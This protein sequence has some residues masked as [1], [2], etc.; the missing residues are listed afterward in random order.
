[1]AGGGSHQRDMAAFRYGGQINEDLQYRVYGN[2]FEVGPNYDPTGQ[3][4]DAWRQGHFGFRADWEPGRDKSNVITVQGDHYLG[5]TDNSVI[6]TD[7]T[8]SDYL[9]G[10]NLLVRWRHVYDEHSDW[11]LQAYYD[12]YTRI[13]AL[14]SE[15]DKT[16]DV[17]FQY[18]FALGDRHSITCGASFRNVES[19]FPG[20]DQFVN[21][22]PYPNLTTN[23]TS[24]FIQDEI[25]LVEDRL[26][27]TLGTKL[28]QNPYTGFEYQPTARVLWPP[29][30]RHSAWCAVSRAVRTPERL[31]EQASLTLA[32]AGEIYDLPLYPRLYGNQNAEFGSND[33][34]SEALVAYELGYREQTTEQLSWDIATFYNVYDHLIVPPA[35]EDLIFPEGSPFSRYILPMIYANGPA[36][37]TY[38]VELA[39]NYSVS[40]RWRLYCQYTLFEMHLTNNPQ[41]FYSSDDPNNQVYLRSSWDLRENLEFD[42]MARYIDRLVVDQV[43]SYIT[44]DARLAYRPRKHLELAVVGQNLLQNHHPEESA[45]MFVFATQ[46]P[47]G[48]YGTLTWRH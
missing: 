10:E 40:K 20:G 41:G 17:D 7:P 22:F 24:E 32:Q 26:T 21:W 38:G 8:L 43:P 1:M 14:Q 11:T 18:R 6:P 48:V 15:V 44:L 35:N 3:I 29:D 13:D 9:T 36:G 4:D 5:T 25:T 34:V 16:F 28:E 12:N 27:F 19:H 42:V 39:A 45:S 37:D 46:V 47:R 33:L 2:H 23:Y 30:R 31:E